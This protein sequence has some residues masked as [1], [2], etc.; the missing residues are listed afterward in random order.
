MTF[1]WCTDQKPHVATFRYR[2]GLP[3][4]GKLPGHHRHP[5]RHSPSNFLAKNQ[6]ISE[7]GGVHPMRYS[8][9]H[10]LEAPPHGTPP[11]SPL[12]INNVNKLNRAQSPLVLNALHRAGGGAVTPTAHLRGAAASPVPPVV[13]SLR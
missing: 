10:M 6:P 8:P 9:A 7:N 2:K 4:T 12:T 1:A 3:L 11:I 13:S 5:H